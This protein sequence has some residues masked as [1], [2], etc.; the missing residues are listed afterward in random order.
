VRTEIEV[1][2]GIEVTAIAMQKD[3]GIDTLWWR[4]MR[5]EVCSCQYNPISGR[6]VYEF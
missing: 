6:D 2:R 3:D 4:A 1:Q 5:F